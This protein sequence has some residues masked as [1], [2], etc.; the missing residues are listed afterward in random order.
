MT[1]AKTTLYKEVAARIVTL[2]DRGIMKE[3]EKIPSIRELSDTL[4]VSLN[5]VKEAYSQLENRYYIE[6]VPQSGFYVRNNRDQNERSGTVDP[7]DM[8]PLQ[9]S[10]CRIYG[11]FQEQGRIPPGVEL[12]I[13]HVD[14]DLLPTGKLQKYLVDA[15][16][17]DCRDCFDYQM[18]PGDLQLRE[19]IAKHYVMNGTQLNGEDLIITNGCHEAVFLSLLAV[20]RPG[21]TVAIETPLYF[22]FVRMLELSQLKILEIPC[23]SDEGMS[24]EA[25]E[26]ALENHPVKA[27]LSIPNFSNPLGSLMPDEKK[28]RI[29]EMSACYGIPLIEDDIHG[30]LYYA[31]KRPL[32]YKAFDK[33]GNTILC[34]SFS[35]TLAPG[36]RVGWVAPGRYY[37]R[38]ESLKSLLNIGTSALTQKALVSF[39]REGGYE[40]FLRRLRRDLK[41]QTAA[42]RELVLE[43]FPAGTKVNDPPGG[44]ILWVEVPE[45]VNTLEL[46]ARSLKEGIAFAPG[47]LF[48][49]RGKYS[50]YLRLTAGVL[51]E[52][53]IKAILHLGKMISEVSNQRG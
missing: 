14:V 1:N 36:L 2:I 17:Y 29:V 47:P 18:A 9:V 8:D 22:N 15:V 25:L 28:A 43:N 10:L 52:N 5:T 49:M 46:F 39:L 32:P 11:A 6:A 30:D 13:A 33:N 31:D 4:G 44:F 42:L 16:R 34:S 38:V 21:D 3:G 27:V 35:K 50:N 51:N 7:T 19:Q 45:S 23:Y 26:F 37:S 41:M 12:A 48:S 24:L 40:R 20:C 53:V